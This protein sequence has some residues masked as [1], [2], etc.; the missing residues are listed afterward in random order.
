[1]DASVLKEMIGTYYDGLIVNGGGGGPRNIPKEKIFPTRVSIQQVKTEEGDEETWAGT[2][3]MLDYKIVKPMRLN[4]MA[5]RKGCTDRKH[6]PV[7]LEL[8]PKGLEDGIWKE[9][10]QVERGFS[11][12]EE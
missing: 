1:M 9:L 4:F 11:C 6:F 10:E 5:H 8:S 12:V 3:D 2:V 7:F